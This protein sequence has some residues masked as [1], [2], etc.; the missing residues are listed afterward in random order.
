MSYCFEGLKSAVESITL[1]EFYNRIV[2]VHSGSDSRG[3]KERK[4][5]GGGVRERKG[6]RVSNE[7]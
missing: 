1:A 3:K 5:G 2:I 4:G 7:S 6:N